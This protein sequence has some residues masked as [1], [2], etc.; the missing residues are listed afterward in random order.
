MRSGRYERVDCI[1]FNGMGENLY[2]RKKI[3]LTTNY[4][5]LFKLIEKFDSEISF[6]FLQRSKGGNSSNVVLCVT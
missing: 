6:F 5:N 2:L 4:Y 3:M 1:Y